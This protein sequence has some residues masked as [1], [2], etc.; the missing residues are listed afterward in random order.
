MRA[1]HETALR[2]LARG[3]EGISLVDDVIAPPMSNDA[4]KG[5]AVDGRDRNATPRTKNGIVWP[6]GRVKALR[7]AMGLSQTLFAQAVGASAQSVVNWEKG[8]SAPVKRMQDRLA[9]LETA[10]GKGAGE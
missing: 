7:T 4:A 3:C 8:Y 9:E 1:G 10:S 6:P 5:I 2:A